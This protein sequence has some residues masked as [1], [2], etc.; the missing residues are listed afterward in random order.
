MT[1]Y[2]RSGRP[3]TYIDDDGESIYRYSGEPVAWLV[4]ENL[5]AYSGAHLGWL[6]NGWVRDHRGNC[7]F[8]T[9]NTSGGGPMKPMRQMKPMRGMRQMRP[10]RGLRRMV[11]M[12][13]MASFSWS[14]VTGEDFFE[15]DRRLNA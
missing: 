12:R 10:M 5:H 2:D 9:E 11:P 8:F 14:D 6:H 4:G 3:I 13:P 7:V 15:A 1:F